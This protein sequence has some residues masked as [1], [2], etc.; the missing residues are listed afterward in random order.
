MSIKIGDTLLKYKINEVDN[1]IITY[2]NDFDEE[3]DVFLN[4]IYHHIHRHYK[5]KK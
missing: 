2:V 5:D 4:K 3:L 1:Y